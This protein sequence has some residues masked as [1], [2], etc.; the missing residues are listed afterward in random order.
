MQWLLDNSIVVLFGGGMIAMHLFGRGFGGS[1]KKDKD[2]PR[3]A[4]ISATKNPA[5]EGSSKCPNSMI[6]IRHRPTPAR[7]PS[8]TR[9]AE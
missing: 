9:C 2:G 7:L 5:D 6:T 4:E 8:P 1:G 3:K